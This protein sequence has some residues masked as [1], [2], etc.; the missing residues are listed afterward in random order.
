MSCFNRKKAKYFFYKQLMCY[1]KTIFDLL[2]SCFTL[3]GRGLVE[4]RYLGMVKAAGS[5]PADSI[6]L[7]FF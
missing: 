7:F 3:W 2:F 6:Y 1:N 5:I 4:D